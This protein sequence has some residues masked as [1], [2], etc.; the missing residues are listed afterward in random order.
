[1][2]DRHQAAWGQADS[3]RGFGSAHLFWIEPDGPGLA[4]WRA[5][6]GHNP[7]RHNGVVRDA[8]FRAA[9]PDAPRCSRCG[10]VE[11]VS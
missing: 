3:G 11:R 1:M 4:S 6:C 5:V 7:T 10:P 2:P 9:A 8:V